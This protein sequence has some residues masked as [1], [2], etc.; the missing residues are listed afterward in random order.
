L[1]K[2]TVAASIALT[3]LILD[4]TAPADA[5][6]KGKN[7]KRGILTTTAFGTVAGDRAILSATATCPK[8]TRAVGG[9]FAAAPSG[10][11]YSALVFES[12]K[13][14]QRQWRAS[15]QMSQASPFTPKTITVE[16]YC[17]RGAPAT[18]T[19]ASTV[20][21]VDAAPFHMNGPATSAPC[22]SNRRLTGGG[23]ATPPPLGEFGA[24]NVVRRSE[25][26]GNSWTTEVESDNHASSVSSYAYCAKLKRSSPL[27]AVAAAVPGA[28]PEPES[29]PVTATCAGKRT[30]VAGGFAQT[31]L[32]EL[33]GGAFQ[34]LESRRVGKSWTAVAEQGGDSTATSFSAVGLC[35]PKSAKRRT[36][37]R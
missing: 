9:G 36:A 19:V 13:V 12:Q 25:P 1:W 15:A 8:R 27:T 32:L 7:Q 20:P 28:N 37:R 6:Q 18:T 5:D 17:R 16:A 4:A 3:A 31:Y 35:A 23:F 24:A 22:P 26:T 34:V 33:G 29:T 10:T 14:G 30:M 11:G 21:T 2:S